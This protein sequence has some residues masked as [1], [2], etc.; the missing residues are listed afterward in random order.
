MQECVN[1]LELSY[2]VQLL[3]SYKKHHCMCTVLIWW[4]S[5]SINVD[6]RI[7][8]DGCHSNSIG[9]QNCS[10]TTCNDAF[11]DTTN[12]SSNHQYVLHVLRYQTI[13]INSTILYWDQPVIIIKLTCHICLNFTVWSPFG[14]LEWWGQGIAHPGREFPGILR[15]VTFST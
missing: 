14:N 2:A 3:S 10:N 8:L 5:S 4:K 12:H 7:D 11:T 15:E 13:Y 9:F 6:I 1:E